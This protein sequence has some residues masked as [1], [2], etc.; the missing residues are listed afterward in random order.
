MDERRTYP[1]EDLVRAMICVIDGGHTLTHCL[2]KN[3]S[4]DGALLECPLAGIHELY[5]VGDR[6]E[7]RDILQEGPVLF[8]KASGQVAWV[9]TRTLGVHFDTPVMASAG[10]LRQWLE[11]QN[12]V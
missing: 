12:L 5:D 6:I 11:D 7:L 8:K 2:V 4:L 3:V 1:R 9:Y 10:E